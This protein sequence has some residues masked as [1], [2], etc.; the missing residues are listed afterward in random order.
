[1]SKPL[2]LLVDD[3]SETVQVLGRMLAEEG[4]VRF[5]L[6]GTDALRLAREQPPDLI[7]LDAEMPGLD[8][9][10]VCKGLK[11][12]P[13]LSP[14]PVIFLTSH[15]DARIEAAALDL[16]A[17]DFVNKPPVASQVIARIRAQLRARRL[18]MSVRPRHSPPSPA[19]LP[20]RAPTLLV[21]DD[22]AI[23]RELLCR[24]LDGMGARILQAADG[25]QAMRM[26]QADPPDLILL[27]ILMPDQDG[28]QL[29]ERLQALPRLRSVPVVFVTRQADPET[30]A[31]ALEAG[32]TDFVAK[33]FIPAVLQ[34]RLRSL[35][36]SRRQADA[37]LQ[38]ERE[39]WRR[40]GD[41]RMADILAVAPEALLTADAQGRV[42]L[43]NQAACRLLQIT[44]DD[45]L[46]HPLPRWVPPEALGGAPQSHRALLPVPRG[47]PIPV[48]V[49]RV[50]LGQDG[51]R[52]TTVW[53]RDLRGQE[54][55][56]KARR[57]QLRAETA[58]R[59]KTL[60]LSYFAHEIGNPLNGILGFAQL[61]TLDGQH[62]LPPAQ[63]ERLQ[64][65]T[66][67]GKMLQAL[68]RDVLDVNRFETGQFQ[69]QSEPVELSGLVR[70]TLPALGTQATGR[71]VRIELQ[72]EEAPLWIAG[73]A[74]RLKQCVLNLGSNGIKYNR[75]G[76]RL[77]VRLGRHEGSAALHFQDEGA[78]MSPEQQAHLFEPFNRLGR[79][80]QGHGIGL[81]LTRQLVLAMGGQL[82][83]QSALEQGTTVT[84][85]FPL[86]PLA[87]PEDGQG[88]TS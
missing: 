53:L 78:G 52:L 11:G 29:C 18:A 50:Q 79:S 38:A 28:L 45:V 12:D 84:L 5:A 34:A 15:H 31:R 22:D 57:D 36:R 88:M 32:G 48:E 1:M 27:D 41:D 47:D 40:L 30:E 55:A 14:I 85:L 23:A 10:A 49:V 62:P 43:V 9:F 72:V 70:D 6:N 8:G 81:A 25:E 35:L 73:D 76:G 59:T 46:G 56:E 83:V 66:T 64:Q 63:A 3:D 26:A 54:L 39:H 16:G 42:V 7:L 67:A 19:A 74:D 61:M 65:I 60:M 86:A 44:E 58:S 20:P 87:R 75:S 24:A 69:I 80:G 2:L 37:A 77:T 68:M 82:S 21:V 33:P 17:A 13:D 4:R 51:E 71:Q